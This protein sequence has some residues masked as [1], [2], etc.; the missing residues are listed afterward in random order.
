MTPGLQ[1][2]CWLCPQEAEHTTADAVGVRMGNGD[3]IP[4]DRACATAD[5][6]DDRIVDVSEVN[7]GWIRS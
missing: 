2:L 6:E 4:A 7:I 1:R 3:V 5:A